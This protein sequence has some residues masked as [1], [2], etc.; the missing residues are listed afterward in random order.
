[1]PEFIKAVELKKKYQVKG[2]FYDLAKGKSVT[3][4]RSL[5]TITDTTLSNKKKLLVVMLNPGSSRPLDS[6]Y[7]ESQIPA[8]QI[9]RLEHV[10]LIDTKPD[11]TQYQIMRVMN[12][13][14]Y[15]Y[16]DVINLYDVREPKSGILFQNAKKGRIPLE[17]SIFSDARQSELN[18]LFAASPVVVLAWGNARQIAETEKN[19]LEKVS[20]LTDKSFLV[21]GRD[22]II[23]H[24]S[25]QMHSFKLKWLDDIYAQLKTGK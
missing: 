6:E 1:M 5:L 19:A 13:F 12:E 4:C 8:S 18:S 24:P 22:N 2:R 7:V 17:A 16:A 10:S 9:N 3:K 20:Q 14:K 23:C 21:R 11:T 25:P 15:S